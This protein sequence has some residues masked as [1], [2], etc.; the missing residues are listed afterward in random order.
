MTT[1]GVSDNR[2]GLSLP[3]VDHQ[4]STLSHL[5]QIESAAQASPSFRILENGSY[6]EYGHCPEHLAVAAAGLV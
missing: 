2:S 1:S 5:A 6:Q 4:R 3:P